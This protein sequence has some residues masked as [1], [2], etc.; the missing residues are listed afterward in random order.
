MFVEDS[1]VKHLFLMQNRFTTLQ[2]SWYEQFCD[3]VNLFSGK[4]LWIQFLECCSIHIIH[5]SYLVKEAWLSFDLH[6]HLSYFNL[7]SSPCQQSYFC[8]M[9]IKCGEKRRF[10]PSFP[11]FFFF[12]LSCLIQRMNEFSVFLHTSFL[13]T[14]CFPIAP[15]GLHCLHWHHIGKGFEK[16]WWYLGNWDKE[17][18]SGFP[19]IRQ[20]YV[21]KLRLS[22]F[23]FFLSVCSASLS[24]LGVHL[25]FLYLGIFYWT[26]SSASS[27][28]SQAVR[29]WSIS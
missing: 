26:L 23:L 9:K 12:H 27:F 6:T 18:P 13:L 24:S 15:A 7:F 29:Y 17:K 1:S 11:F 19:N 22:F 3:S 16:R 2:H 20:N 8:R 25:I 10:G 21:T 14:R 5:R 4:G 28:Q